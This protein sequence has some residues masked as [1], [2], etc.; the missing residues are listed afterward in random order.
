VDL[1][2]LLAALGP[3]ER[4]RAFYEARLGP[5]REY[6]RIHNAHLV[7]T[8]GAYFACGR[9]LAGAA[10]YLNKHR[11]TVLYRLRL[12]EEVTGIDLRDPQTE[13]ELQVALHIAAALDRAPSG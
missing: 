2:S 10:Q 12:I 5:L 8:L 4:M 6:D 9:S 3:P 7:A 1:E 13:L 11:N